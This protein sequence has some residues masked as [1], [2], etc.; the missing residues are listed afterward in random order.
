M[1]QDL[2]NFAS[3]PVEYTNANFQKMRDKMQEHFDMN[4]SHE[5]LFKIDCD[6][7]EMWQLYLNTLPPVQGK[8]NLWH[9][10]TSCHRWFRKVANLVALTSDNEIITLWSGETIL[11]YQNVFKALDNFLKEHKQIKEAFYTS[12]DEVGIKT[13]YTDDENGDVWR[14]DHFYLELPSSVVRDGIKVGQT[15]DKV[16][17][18]RQVFESSLSQ[19]TLDA[20]NE[21]IELIE[22]NNLYRGQQWYNQLKKF[23]GLKTQVANVSEDDLNNWYW[24]KSM[25]VGSVISKIKNHSIG[26]LLLDLSKGA[27]LEVALK[28]YEQVVAPSNYQRPKEIFTKKM[29]EEAKQKIEELGYSESLK[30]RYAT[31]EDLS[32]NDVI[33]ADRSIASNLQ[34]TDDFFGMLEQEAIVSPKSFNYIQAISLND[35]ID[36]VIPDAIS[37]DL[38][39]EM[40]LINNFVSL[41]APV[42]KDAPSMFKWDNPFCWAYKNNMADS[43]KE[44]VKAMGGDVDVDLRFS[45][46]WNNLGEWDKSD[47]DAHCTEPGTDM[48]IREIFYSNKQSR[49]GTGGWLDVDIIDPKKDVPAVENIRFKDKSKMRYGEYLFRVHQFTAR[50]GNAGFE[51]EIEFDGTIYH[52]THYKP[53]RQNEYVDVAKVIYHRDGHFELIPILDGSSS[54]VESWNIKMNDFVPVNLICYSPNYW[55]NN[56]VGNQHVFFML[57]DC[58]SDDTPNAWFN[59]YLD[60]E[61]KENHK[62]VM[63]ALGRAAKVELTDNQLS[64]IG[65]AT[66]RA[67][68]VTFKVVSK[69]NKEQIYKVIV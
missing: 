11:E 32:I 55:G 34:N 48:E 35:F 42:N 36:N 51:A 31:M 27:D 3:A 14:N 46:R 62:K 54:N 43:M 50:S 12:R 8:T 57:K 52:F 20:L 10:C 47:L 19:I 9:D 63:E 5:K 69:D 17:T 39:T 1:T 2:S 58:I 56:S 67:N 22:D 53:L 38:Y 23:R 18:N 64:G 7:E 44:Q 13:T 6:V 25:E 29:L 30:R 28:R 65:L 16:A 33:F 37:I 66:T 68:E 41:I 60:N 4:M 49:L 15:K 45:I 59:E 40:P 26:V 24:I 21:V 61:L